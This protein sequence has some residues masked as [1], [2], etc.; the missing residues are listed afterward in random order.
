MEL[1]HLR[2]FVM[3]AEEENISHAAA[4][5]HVSQPAVSRQIHNL[6]DEL[7]VRLFDR[8]QH[9]LVL[10]PAGQAALPQAQA[11]LRQTLFLEQSMHHLRTQE[12]TASLKIGFIPSALPGLLAE[13]LKT[14]NR[15]HPHVCAKIFEM[16]PREQERALAKN[17]IDLALLGA[18]R[19]VLR[20]RYQH[21]PIREAHMAIVVSA[22]HPLAHRQSLDLAELGAETFLSL[23][24]EHFPRRHK[25]ISTLFAKA[26]IKPKIALH[27]SGLT[28]L[29]GLVG[30]GVGIALI[31]DDVSKLAH[32]GVVFI[33]M[34]RPVFKLA[35]AAVWRKTPQRPEIEDLVDLL[36]SAGQPG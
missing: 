36:E 17:E 32:P 6:E 26:G 19:A 22:E 35:S 7:G 4:R 18:P 13:A 15:T 2:Y 16:T 10:T 12:K 34:R 25:S 28:E 23:D 31:P 20:E 9:G 5:L 33:K 11:I 29:L 3:A 24:E 21:R 14:Y 27:A 1:R 8:A 30:A